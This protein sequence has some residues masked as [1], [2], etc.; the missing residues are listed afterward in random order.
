VYAAEHR[1]IAKTAPVLENH[2]TQSGTTV[3][4]WS[5]VLLGL[6]SSGVGTFV[7]L[8]A[9]SSWVGRIAGL[10]FALVGIVFIG[11][12]LRGVWRRA[13]TEML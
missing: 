6:V 5:S 13:A 3:H 4:R 2:P 1:T 9:W 12:G 10:L 11:H 7:C 8:Q